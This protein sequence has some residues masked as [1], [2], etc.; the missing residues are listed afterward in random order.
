MKTR[1]EALKLIGKGAIVATGVALIGPGVALAKPKI[2]TWSE[3]TPRGWKRYYVADTFLN[4]KLAY[5]AMERAQDANGHE[6]IKGFSRDMAEEKFHREQF[7]K[8]YIIYSAFM[9]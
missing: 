2:E 5:R 7:N 9:K 3:T 8:N 1:R 6:K 4:E